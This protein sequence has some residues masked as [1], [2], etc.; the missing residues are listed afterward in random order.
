MHT[1]IVN[2]PF[3]FAEDGNRVIEIEAGEQQVSER[4]ALVAVDHLKVATL[5]GSA[6]QAAT[7]TR[8]KAAQ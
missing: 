1:I 5:P 4:C 7:K 2:K 8:T 6:P 3:L